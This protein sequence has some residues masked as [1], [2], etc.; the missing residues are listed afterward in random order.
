MKV[1][2]PRFVPQ[3]K[4]LVLG[5][6]LAG[7]VDGAPIAVVEAIGAAGSVLRVYPTL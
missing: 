1:Q 7:V 2:R 5:V 6:K 4:E 3:P